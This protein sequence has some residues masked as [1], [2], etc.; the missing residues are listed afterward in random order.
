M[1]NDI[2]FCQDCVNNKNGKCAAAG[3]SKK[4]AEHYAGMARM[5]ICFAKCI[6]HEK[7]VEVLMGLAI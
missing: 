5:G 6:D 1:I 4:W 2:Q 7:A 3:R